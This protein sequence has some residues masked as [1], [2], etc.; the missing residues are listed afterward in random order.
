MLPIHQGQGGI[1]PFPLSHFWERLEV[2]L[3]DLLKYFV[4]EL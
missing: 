4:A 1:I 3:S 2:N